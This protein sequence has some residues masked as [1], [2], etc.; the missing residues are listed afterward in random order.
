[1][2]AAKETTGV[3]RA[4]IELLRGDEL[5]LF[6]PGSDSYFKVSPKL[7][8][9]VSF[10]TE[11]IQLD[12][13]LERLSR[14]GISATMDEL[15]TIL[16]FLRSNN[17]LIPRQGE[18]VQ[19]QKKLKQFKEKNRLLSFSSSY[20]FF[21]LPPWR[22]ET[23]FKKIQPY[24]SF[25]GSKYLLFL[26]M[27]PA[28]AG[29]ITALRDL[30]E[31]FAVF[32]NTLSW[33][34]FVK[35]FAAIVLL[36]LLHE[37]AHSVAAVHFNCR[38]RGIG[39]GFMLFVPRLYTDTT[40]SWRLPRKKRL[41]IDAAGII[42]E[43]LCG[44]IA[45]LL[46][47]NL[48]PGAVRSTMFYIFTVST[49]STLLVNGNPFIRYDGY[50]ILSDL[51]HIENMMNRASD[52][53]KKTWRYLFRLD[54][55]PTDEHRVFLTVFG[56]SAFIYRIFLYTSIC[57]MIYH[58]FT[59]FIAVIMLLLEFYALLIYPVYREIREIRALSVKKA[60]KAFWLWL[61]VLI[62]LACG[63]LFMP[64]SWGISL[65]GIAVPSSRTPVTIAESGYLIDKFE[66]KPRRVKQGD[67]L[68]QLES[69]HLDF[70]LEKLRETQKFDKLLFTLQNLDEKEFSQRAVTAKKI[71]SDRIGIIELQR[72]KAK[73]AV[74][75]EK[76]GVFIPALPDSSAGSLLFRNRH[77]GEI[78]SEQTVIHAYADD[79]EIGKIRVGNTGKITLKD[80]LVSCKVRVARVDALASKLEASALLQVFGGPIPVYPSE[81]N[82]YTPTQTLYCVELELLDK[83]PV[84]AGRIVSV[85][86]DHTEQLCKYISRFVLSFFLKEF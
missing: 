56:I 7:V 18:V 27:I 61:A 30:S 53:V 32:E 75:A 37:A 65:H 23:F 48:A 47:F 66:S 40:D 55:L 15:K 83:M 5:M 79:Q 36:K 26:L 25:L 86:I 59:K 44:G 71:D 35:Y 68:F 74:K 13:F 6:D 82:R 19:Q 24:I 52:C 62:L 81:D 84:A 43:L 4:D 58:K 9:I 38:V 41:L 54:E 70:A 8:Q 49:L 69:P 2:Q 76:E 3:L 31:I 80:N 33:A 63:V 21:R 39:L 50:Y 10:L 29:Y 51:L 85:K 17:L 60:K 1:M 77:A 78:V 20:L 22:P 72:R 57:L 67:V 34:G 46:W 45:A 64:L 14:N 42:V 16:V 73:L 11:D 12:T 28:L